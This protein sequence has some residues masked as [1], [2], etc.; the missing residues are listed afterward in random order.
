MTIEGTKVF[1]YRMYGVIPPNVPEAAIEGA[2]YSAVSWCQTIIPHLR[3][4]TVIIHE[5][6]PEDVAGSFGPK[7]VQ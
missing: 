1:E 7:I 3:G 5:K 2:V 6:A 4:A